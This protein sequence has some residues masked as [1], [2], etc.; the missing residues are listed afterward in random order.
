M[1]INT[2]FKILKKL[3]FELAYKYWIITY[4][5]TD[6]FLAKKGRPESMD[7]HTCMATTAGIE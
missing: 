2:I 3:N 5:N 7:L 1:K 6:F 4:K